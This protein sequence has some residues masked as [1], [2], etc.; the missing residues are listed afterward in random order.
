M[1]NSK[2]IHTFF[3]FDIYTIYLIYIYV[4][5]AFMAGVAGRAG[6]AGSSRAPGLTSGLRGS[7]GV[8][9]GAL[10]LVPQ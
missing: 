5:R 1:V 9:H 4:S 3:Y 7:M 10:L 8:H 6:G 2:G